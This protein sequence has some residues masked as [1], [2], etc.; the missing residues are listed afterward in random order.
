MTDLTKRAAGVDR[1]TR[2][3]SDDQ[4]IETWLR[5]RASKSPETERAYRRNAAAWLTWLSRDGRQLSSASLEDLQDFAASLE[6]LYALESRRQIL[7]TVKSLHTFAVK[8]GY[9]RFNVGAAVELPAGVDTLAQKILSYEFILLMVTHEPSDR[10]KLLLRT[11]YVT[12]ARVSEIARL[13][14]QD[15][16]TVSDPEAESYGNLTLYGKGAKTR[17]VK[18]PSYLYSDLEAVRAGD[19][20]PLF[21][22]RKLSGHLT[23]EQ[24]WRIVGEAARRVPGRKKNP[25]KNVGPH[26][27]RHSH[28]SHALSAGAPITV[29]QDQLGHS[30]TTTTRRYAKHLKKVSSADW[31]ESV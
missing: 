2:A 29:I 26:H 17:T 12:G 4:L 5:A 8:S 11:L 31:L 21:P 27:L 16:R 18:V 7:A 28:A 3:A 1:I 24:I 10:N 19:D 9:L 22:S 15:L 13:K 23:T 6:K 14:W 30:D 20:H 25:E